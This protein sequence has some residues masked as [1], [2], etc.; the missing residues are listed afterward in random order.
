[1]KKLLLFIFF[2]I[3]TS[4][5][6]SQGLSVDIQTGLSSFKMTDLKKLNSS[7][8]MPFKTK[9]LSDY[10]AYYYFQP[11]IFLTLKNINVGLSYSFHATGSRISRKD[12]S[13][14]Y[15]FDTKVKS[16]SYSLNL[17]YNTTQNIKANIFIYSELGILKS[18]LNLKE[19]FDLYDKNLIN[20][21]YYFTSKNNYFEPGIK[22]TYPIRGLSFALNFGY[23]FQFGK[24]SFQQTGNS[25]NT[26]TIKAKPNWAGYR[27]GISIR[28][29]LS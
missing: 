24:G 23:F 28:Y 4:H 6:Y 18:F 19:Y 11:S 22:I 8:H 3:S 29:Q 13:G 12:Y 25:K 21:K 27:I 9:L 20:D 16:N 15:Y 14:E 1:M 17:E 7:I 5:I 26:L 10:P 2:L